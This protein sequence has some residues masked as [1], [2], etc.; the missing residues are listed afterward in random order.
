MGFD[1]TY[2]G[3]EKFTHILEHL[4]MKDDGYEQFHECEKCSSFTFHIFS[5]RAE[6]LTGLVWLGWYEWTIWARRYGSSGPEK[7]NVKKEQHLQEAKVT[8]VYKSNLELNVLIYKPWTNH[9]TN[10]CSQTW[11]SSS[12]HE[13]D[14]VLQLDIAASSSI[15]PYSATHSRVK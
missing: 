6:N 10:A 3:M 2:A 7:H 5:T 12:L 8:S 15:H 14:T 13:P 4:K 11:S 9:I 1:P